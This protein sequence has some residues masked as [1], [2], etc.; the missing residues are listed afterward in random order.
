MNADQ[1]LQLQQLIS[2]HGVEDN[3]EL[4]RKLK[5]SEVLR[6]E[7]NTLLELKAKGDDGWSEEAM[8]QCSFLF[9]YYTDLYNKVRKDEI[10]LN[11]LFQA[12]DVL[13]SIEEGKVDQHEGAF[14]FGQLLKQIYIDSA[15]KKSAKLEEEH[16]VEKADYVVA[17]DTSLSWAEWKKKDAEAKAEQ[18]RIYEEQERGK[19]LEE[20]LASVDKAKSKANKNKGGG[21]GKK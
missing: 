15:L 5:H 13:A 20:L 16:R 14:Q 2:E 4:I 1:R 10:D 7:V 19:A 18:R 12:L 8:M 6:S 21:K 11:I 17:E 9:T 3:T